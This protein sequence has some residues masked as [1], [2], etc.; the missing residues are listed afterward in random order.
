M[1]LSLKDYTTP[2]LPLRSCN[3]IHS[4]SQKN[5]NHQFTPSRPQS[6][7]PSSNQSN[8]SPP[9]TINHKHSKHNHRQPVGIQIPRSTCLSDWIA[10]GVQAA[11]CK[12][13]PC[14]HRAR[15]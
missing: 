10:H 1:F 2:L 7:S 6:L 5:H 15:R 11:S 13:L 8:N 4:Q 14:N 12:L 3:A 9:A